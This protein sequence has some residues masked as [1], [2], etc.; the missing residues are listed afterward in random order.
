MD[1]LGKTKEAYTHIRNIEISLPEIR[2]I[3]ENTNG[4]SVSELTTEI[5]EVFRK[6][7][8][9]DSGYGWVFSGMIIGNLINPSGRRDHLKDHNKSRA[10][11]GHKRF[12]NRIDTKTIPNKNR[13]YMHIIRAG[14]EDFHERAGHYS[15]KS[16]I[17][18]SRTTSDIR[19]DKHK[20]GYKTKDHGRGR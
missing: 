8:T 1:E 9:T 7:N 17:L 11:S 3:L 4:K 16:T 14:L 20:G 6:L 13:Y 10:H 15:P 5:N 2:K 19:L 18:S 12:K